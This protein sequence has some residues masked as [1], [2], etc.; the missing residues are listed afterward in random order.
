[1]NYRLCLLSLTAACGLALFSGCDGQNTT[2]FTAEESEQSFEYGRQLSKQGRNAEALNAY[3]KVIAKRGDNAPESHLEAALIYQQHIKDH[4]AAIYH[5]RKYLELQ[6]N[7]RQAELVRGR[8][9][10]SKREFARTLPAHPM[11]DA[12]IKMSYMEQLER[13]QRENDQLKSELSALRA[14]LPAGPLTNTTVT[15]GGFD[16]P[17]GIGMPVRQMP[18]QPA[19]T[20]QAVE[21][22][23]APQETASDSP[24]LRAPVEAEP[25]EAADPSANPSGGYAS[26]PAPSG[27]KTVQPNRPGQATT[28]RPTQPPAAQ[29]SRRHVVQPKDT[30][31]SIS[32]RYYGTR[33]RVKDIAAANRDVLKGGDALHP[34]MELRL[35]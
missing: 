5:F 33:G 16:I 19:P 1:M 28:Q 2:T 12:S 20:A 26:T 34:G 30:L 17:G 18:P 25:T 8:I 21:G 23:A 32:L 24:F 13:F 3:L 31:S 7:S 4:I 35:P 27:T 9:D 15:R 6:P 11:E 22:E 10:V 14:G 29:G